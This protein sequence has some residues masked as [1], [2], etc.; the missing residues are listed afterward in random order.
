MVSFLF[1]WM[2]LAAEILQDLFNVTTGR[3]RSYFVSYLIHDPSQFQ[4]YNAF[5]YLTI[6]ATTFASFLLVGFLEIGQEM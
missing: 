2:R 3:Y 1:S 6:P 5:G 4:L